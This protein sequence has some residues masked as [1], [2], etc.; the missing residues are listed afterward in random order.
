MGGLPIYGLM[1]S[2]AM[3]LKFRAT[4]RIVPHFALFVEKEIGLIIPFV[5]FLMD[6][7]RVNDL[8]EAEEIRVIYSL[9]VYSAL[10]ISF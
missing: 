6:R 10:H 3:L 2:E 8:I 1:S 4:F 5:S 9:V 7:Y